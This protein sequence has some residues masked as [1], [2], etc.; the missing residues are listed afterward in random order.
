MYYIEQQNDELVKYEVELNERELKDLRYKIVNDCGEISHK[1]YDGTNYPNSC[2]Y[3]HIRNYKQKKIGRTE[4]RDFFTSAEDIYHFE[5]DEYKDTKLV[6]L[7][8]RLLNG[9]T[10]VIIEL[11]NPTPEEKVD[12]EKIVLEKMEAKQNELKKASTSTIMKENILILE[13]YLEELKQIT[14]DKELNKNRK[15][16]LDYYT[17]VLEYITLK[18]VDRIKIDKFIQLNKLYEE[19][20]LFFTDSAS[21]NISKDVDDGIYKRLIKM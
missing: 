8:N 4:P 14:S 16:D 13:K 19:L 9:E 6:T 1:S 20:E 18:E 15:S 2:D 17:K 11:K 12:K 7:I 21:K 5:Y 10:S 3:I